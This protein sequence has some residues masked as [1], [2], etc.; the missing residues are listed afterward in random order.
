MREILFRGQTRRFGEKV[1]NFAGEPMPSN[2]VYG[3]VCCGKGAFSIIYDYMDEE[4]EKPIEKHVVYTDTVGQYT[5][6]TDKNGRKIFEGDICQTKGFPLIDDKPFVVEWNCDECSFYW[7]DV[8]GTDEFTTG[9]AEN[10]TIIGN[11]H[12]NPELM[13][14]GA[15]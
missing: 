7:R 10:T 11:I 4:K 1:K 9:V 6:L 5:G 8:L 13:K 12:D 15:E 3:G 2:W 14:G